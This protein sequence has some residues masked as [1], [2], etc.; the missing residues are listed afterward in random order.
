M[1]VRYFSTK[2]IVVSNS[3]AKHWQA[4]LKK[5]QLIKVY[6][7]IVF[8]PKEPPESTKRKTGQDITVTSIA[9][10]IPSKGHKYFIEVAKE[11][12]KINSKFQFLIVGDTFQGYESYEEK[13]KTLVVENNLHE[14]I[15][16]L[17]L[18]SDVESILSKSDLVFHSSITPDSLPTV[19]FEA[20]KMR[21][22]VAATD[23]AGAVEILDNGN[24]G[25]LL[26]LNNVKKAAHMI[27]DYIND[28]KLKTSNIEKAIEHTN[29]YFS[30]TK[31]EKNIL[32]I[33]KNTLI[34]K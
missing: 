33:F 16:F 30:P 12:L 13:L 19:L 23:L 3:V 14:K 5:N 31:F 9:R 7:G 4:Y 34:S 18:R 25:L 1:F 10:L 6:N 22:P 2:V 21:V 15:H 11:L 17:G 28:E 32:D 24:C 27:N 29:Q 26:P 8:S 20:I